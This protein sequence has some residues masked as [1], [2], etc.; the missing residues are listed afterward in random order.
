MNKEIKYDPKISHLLLNHKSTYV[1]TWKIQINIDIIIV[2]II[3]SDN[4]FVSQWSSKQLKY[5][6]SK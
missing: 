5:R 3:N 4:G 2:H 1:W 6:K